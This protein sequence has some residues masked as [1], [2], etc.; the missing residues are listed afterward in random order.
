M[1]RGAIALAAGILLIGLVPGGVMAKPSTDQSFATCTTGT[2]GKWVLAQTFRAGMTGALTEVDLDISESTTLSVT[3]EIVN[4]VGFGTASKPGGTVLDHG[5]ASV[6]GEKSYQF[7][8]SK[9]LII[10]KGHEYAI[11]LALGSTGYWCGGTAHPYTGGKSWAKDPTWSSLPVTFDF[12]T[13]VDPA[14]APTP[15]FS[16]TVIWM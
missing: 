13:W 14:L 9:K 5:N 15:S 7:A 8:L 10:T 4:A 6:G 2:G 3:A 12:Q 11:E 16:S 1:K